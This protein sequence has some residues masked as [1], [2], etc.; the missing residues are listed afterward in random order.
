MYILS[1]SLLI[2]V[3]ELCALYIVECILDNHRENPK[4]NVVPLKRNC[5]NYQDGNSHSGNYHDGNY[6]W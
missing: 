3:V 2:Y 4:T 5:G 6:Q 1:F